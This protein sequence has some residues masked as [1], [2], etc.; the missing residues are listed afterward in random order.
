VDVMLLHTNPK[1]FERAD[2]TRLGLVSA[3]CG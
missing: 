3:A 1:I 2:L